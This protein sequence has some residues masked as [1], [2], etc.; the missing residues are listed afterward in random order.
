MRYTLM[1]IVR[2]FLEYADSEFTRD[3]GESLAH[4]RDLYLAARRLLRSSDLQAPPVTDSTQVPLPNPVLE[5]L[6]WRVENQLAKL[7]QG[8]NIAGMKRQVELPAPAASL[9]SGLPSAGSSDQLP[10]PPSQVLRPTPYRY[11]VVIER[12]KQ[13]ANIAQQM[14]ANYLSLIEKRDAEEAKRIEAGYRLDVAK[15]QTAYM[16]CA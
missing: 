15:R 8:R 1:S 16:H 10:A 11:H 12:S 2:C 7:R 13:M 6:R 5:S 9:S 3:T 4:A 14:E